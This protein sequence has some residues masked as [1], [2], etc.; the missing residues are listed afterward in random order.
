MNQTLMWKPLAAILLAGALG[1]CAP[2]RSEDSAEAVY[3]EDAEEVAPA[4]PEPTATPA[5][6]APPV[7][8]APRPRPAAPQPT[9]CADCGTV[10]AVTPVQVKGEGSGAGAVIGA[11]AGGVAGH[12]VGGGRGKDVATAAGVILGAMA[13]HEVE[14]R[15]RSVTVYDI[16]VRMDTGG[17]RVIRVA[18]PAGIAVGTPVRVEGNNIYLR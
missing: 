16:S 13:G 17:Q 18:E 14:K 8:A 1:A 2:D 4:T 3:E 11:V 6:A 10:A 5:P 7:A 12:Q 15:T 9:V